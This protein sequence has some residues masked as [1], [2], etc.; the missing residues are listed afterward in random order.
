VTTGR[1]LVERWVGRETIAYNMD[2]WGY[3]VY[4][5]SKPI[6]LQVTDKT[7]NRSFKSGEHDGDECTA[8]ECL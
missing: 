8:C 4:L 6:K 3:A 2:N 5:K 1:C 7:Y